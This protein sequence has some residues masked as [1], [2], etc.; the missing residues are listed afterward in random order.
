ML[1]HVTCCKL[2]LGAL[3]L[4]I[5]HKIIASVFTTAIRSKLLDFDIVLCLCPCSKYLVGIESF[6]FGL[7]QLEPGVM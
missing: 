5:L 2:S 6:I 4:K 1:R 3:L 7:Q